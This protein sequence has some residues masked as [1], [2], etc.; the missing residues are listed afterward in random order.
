MINT[1]EI[2]EARKQID[3][4][5]KESKKVIVVAKDDEFNRKILE[6]KKVN[7]I[8][9]LEFFRKDKLKQRDSGLNEHLCK[10]AREN[11]IEILIDLDKIRSLSEKEKAETLSRIV[12]NIDLCKR[13]R[14][15]VSFLNKYKKQ[16]VFS[17]FLTFNGSTEQAKRAV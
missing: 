9:G 7:G 13:T 12:Q 4:L 3:K 8:L 2:N 11:N 16:D 10:L 1:S 15:K 6:N 14:T 5:N 17:F